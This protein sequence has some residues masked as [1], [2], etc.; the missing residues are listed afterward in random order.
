MEDYTEWSELHKYVNSVRDGRMLATNMMLKV[1]LV[2]GA[3]IA[4]SLVILRYL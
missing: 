1:V 3:R 4:D 2:E